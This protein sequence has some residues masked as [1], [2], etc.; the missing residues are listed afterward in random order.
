MSTMPKLYKKFFVD[1]NNERKELFALIQQEYQSK[2]VLYPGSFT[3]IAPSFYF[4]EVVYLDTDK[5]CKSFF[6]N[7]ETIEFVKKNKKYTGIP[8]IQFHETD[9][10]KEIDETPEYFDLLISQYSGFISKYCTKYLKKDGILLAND[11]HGDATYA[12]VSGDYELI[13]VITDDMKIEYDNLD[14]YF[15]FSRKKE[16]DIEKVLTDMK[17]PKY[18]NIAYSYIFK[19]NQN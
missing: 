3:H 15:L 13:A 10:T 11:S 6:S 9:F 17:G 19:K 1:N 2:K 4:Q 5:R 7:S 18:K 8:S 12:Y 14:T 16:I